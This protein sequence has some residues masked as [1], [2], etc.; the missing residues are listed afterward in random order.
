MKHMFKYLV[1]GLLAMVLLVGCGKQPATEIN[2]AKAAVDA[3]ITEGA[4]KFAPEDAKLL[5]DALT[6]AMDE[7]KAQDAKVF[8][9]YAKAKEML[10]KVKADAEALKTKL[11]EKKEQ[12]KAN[13]ITAQEIATAAVADAKKLL[14]KAPKGKGAMADI[15]ALKADLKG[16]EES[17]KEVQG[18]IDTEDYASATDK[19]N[20][21][22]EKA[23]AVSEQ[24]NQALQ[25]VGKK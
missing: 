16:I 1:F 7:V 17:L 24:I 11:P 14:T 25:K 19:A 18:L 23:K 9:N 8:K 20:A 22:T 2:D 12:A 21:I 6:A 13:A 15:E 10:V 5:N 3:V 4:S